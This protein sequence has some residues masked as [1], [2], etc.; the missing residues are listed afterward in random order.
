MRYITLFPIF[1]YMQN[2]KREQKANCGEIFQI[3]RG[4]ISRYEAKTHRFK[5]WLYGFLS[6]LWEVVNL[7]TPSFL[8]LMK[9]SNQLVNQPNNPCCLPNTG[10]ALTTRKWI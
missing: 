6:D 5:S 1:H 10:S 2:K 8:S 4:R 9:P 3:I 7:L